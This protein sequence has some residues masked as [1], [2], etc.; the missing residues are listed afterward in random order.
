MLQFANL[1]M[2]VLVEAGEDCVG[3]K[4]HVLYSRQQIKTIKLCKIGQRMK[5]NCVI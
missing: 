5:P 4:L 2:I 1:N 3:D